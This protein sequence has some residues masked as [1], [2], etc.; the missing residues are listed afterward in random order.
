MNIRVQYVCLFACKGGVGLPRLCMSVC[1]CLPTCLHSVYPCLSYCL[2]MP[3]CLPAC[4][5]AACLLAA[6]L[7][8]LPSRSTSTL[9]IRWSSQTIRRITSQRASQL[10][11]SL[12]AVSVSACRSLS[13]CMSLSASNCLS[14]CLCLFLFF[15]WDIIGQNEAQHCK[16]R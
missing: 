8:A 6:C 3:A 14:F 1:L 5:P 16:W 12:V 10:Q 11:A 9:L 15:S 7:P 13:L 4:L 2:S